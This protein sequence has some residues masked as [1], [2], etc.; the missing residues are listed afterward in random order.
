MPK[1][2]AIIYIMFLS[3]TV[4]ILIYLIYKRLNEKDDFEHR[5]N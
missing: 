2:L 4:I 1:F 5:D 3:I